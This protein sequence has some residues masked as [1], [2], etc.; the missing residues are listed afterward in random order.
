MRDRVLHNSVRAALPSEERIMHLAHMWTRHPFMLAYAAVACLAM[1]AFAVAVGVEQWG[2]RIG[3]GLAAGAV[4]SMA[5]TEYRVLALT[6]EGLVLFRSSK[7]RQK[8]TKL[9]ERLPKSA[10]VQPVG[11]NLVI[12][13]WSVGD[14]VYSVMKRHQNA[15]VAIS[16]R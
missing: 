3:L 12:T 1:V 2:G 10:E 8:A 4:A 16:Q 13:D 9:L 5:A 15:M 11:S 6:T 7:T 14:Q